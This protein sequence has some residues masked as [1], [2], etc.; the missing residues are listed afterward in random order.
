MK[1]KFGSMKK[2]LSNQTEKEKSQVWVG[3]ANWLCPFYAHITNSCCFRETKTS[4]ESKD[5]GT[6]R[7]LFFHISTKFYLPL[8]VPFTFYQGATFISVE[9]LLNNN[10]ARR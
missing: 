5:A 7:K 2:T 10:K 4:L 1:L 6:D 8:S 9:S 3:I